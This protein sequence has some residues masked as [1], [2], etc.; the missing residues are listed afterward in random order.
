MKKRILI[1]NTGGTISSVKT[2]HGYE[3][4]SGYVESA[5]AQ[6]PILKHQ[7]MPQV[8]QLMETDLCGELQH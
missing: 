5:L 1:I 2:E 4:V 8:K 7:D 3:P 6:I